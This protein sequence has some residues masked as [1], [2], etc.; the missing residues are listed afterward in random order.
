MSVA[1]KVYVRCLNCQK[2]Y[3]A[4]LTP[5]EGLDDAPGDIDELLESNFLRS[6]RF[7]CDGCEC[8]IATVTGVKEVRSG[9]SIRRLEACF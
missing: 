8:A 4:L 5:P 1:F 9:G 3:G 7:V 6:Q 2:D